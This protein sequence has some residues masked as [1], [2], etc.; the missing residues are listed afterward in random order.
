MFQGTTPSGRIVTYSAGPAY[1]KLVCNKGRLRY[2]DASE[3]KKQRGLR[4]DCAQKKKIIFWPRLTKKPSLGRYFQ[5]VVRGLI[6]L[7]A[8][9]RARKRL[10]Y[11]NGDKSEK[12]PRESTEF[13][14]GEKGDS[15]TTVRFQFVSIKYHAKKTKARRVGQRCVAALC[16][17]LMLQGGEG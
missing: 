4:V 12:R 5:L 16:S 10:I 8:W 2:E 15:K 17:E 6:L 14:G 3:Y 7:H 11:N 1:E 13:Y 9:P